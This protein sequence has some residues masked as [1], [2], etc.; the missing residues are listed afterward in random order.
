MTSQ[1]GE[2]FEKAQ[3]KDVDLY[4]Q[5]VSVMRQLI[6]ESRDPLDLLRELVSNAAAREVQA[7]NI[8]IRCYPHPED[9][10][11]FEVQDD[12]I[13]M[14]YSEGTGSQIARLNRF[15]SLGLSAVVGAKSDEFSWKGLGSKLAFHSRR[16]TGGDLH[17]IRASPS[18]RSKCTVGHHC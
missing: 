7:K 16:L 12:G 1:M 14:D 17:R 6:E 15:L 10:Y 2:A 11:I 8:W 4:I 9:I 13:G 18:S 3:A 5:E